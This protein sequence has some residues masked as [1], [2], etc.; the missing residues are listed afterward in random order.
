MKNPTLIHAADI[1]PQRW[2]NGGGWTRQLLSWPADNPDWQLRISLA[3]IEAAGPFSAFPGVQRVL[4]VVVGAGVLLTVD[5]REHRLTPASE[6]LH[7][8]GGASAHAA[9]IAGAT[10]DLNLMVKH[11]HGD[12][13]RAEQG[14]PWLSGC[15]QSGIFTAVD[16]AL[17]VDLD[18]P[19]PLSAQTLLWLENAAALSLRFVPAIAATLLPAWW[20]SFAPYSTPP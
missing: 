11:G 16:G 20:L 5:D 13:L 9:P 6:P 15:A 10:T 1:A 8:D 7:F 4:A 18:P 14:V 12:L 17:Y 3:S 2:R 19:L